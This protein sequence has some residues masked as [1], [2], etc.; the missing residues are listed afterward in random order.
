ML[1]SSQESI[2]IGSAL[3]TI[4]GWNLRV[5]WAQFRHWR[6]SQT[7]KRELAEYRKTLWARIAKLPHDTG[8]M[9]ESNCSF[10]NEFYG[11]TFSECHFACEQHTDN[12][13]MAKNGDYWQSVDDHCHGSNVGEFSIPV[14]IPVESE[15]E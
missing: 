2:L 14:A 3:G 10:I 4:L 6:Y 15:K 13:T 11:A 5:C 9:V 12:I 8:Y 7:I 1:L